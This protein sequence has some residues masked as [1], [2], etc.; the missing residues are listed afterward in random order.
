MAS[1]PNG[2]RILWV[3]LTWVFLPLFAHGQLF[4]PQG[5]QYAP[6]GLLPGDQVYPT[7]SIKAGGGMVVWEDNYTDG[8][9]AGVSAR[10]L[11]GSLSGS[12]SVFRVNATGAFDQSRPCVAALNDGGN[13]FAWQGG[14]PSFQHIYV[15]FMTSA[16]IWVTT[17]DV[18]ASTSTN[19]YQETPAMTVLTGGDVVVIWASINQES[20][21]SM[22]G[23]Y[24]QRFNS[25]GAKVGGEFLINQFTSYNQRNPSIAALS[26]GRFVVVWVSEQQ[27][28]ENT[29]GIYGRLYTAVG[30]PVS[31]EFLVSSA[32]DG[33]TNICANPTVAAA[34][35][36]SFAVSWGQYQLSQQGTT[37]INSNS[38]DVYFRTFSSSAIGGTISRLNTTRF[39][40]Q[41][42]PRLASSGTEYLTVWTSMG[43]DGSREGVYGRYMSGSGVVQGAEFRVNTTTASQQIY[44]AIAGDVSGRFLVSW[45]SFNS[46]TTG[47]DLQA[48]RYVNTNASLSA[49]GA[50]IVTVISSNTLSVSWPMV[51]GFS[52]ANYEVFADGAAS[53]TSVVTNTYWN[54]TGLVPASLHYYRIAYVLTD[55]RRSPLSGSATNT[56]Y[57]AGA[58]WGGIPQEWMAT[59]FGGDIFSWPSPYLDTDGDGASNK[60]EFMAGTD[61]TNTNSVLKIRLQPTTLGLYLNWNTQPGLMYQV[62]TASTPGSAWSNLGGPRFAAGAVDSIFVGGGSSAVYRIQR[63]R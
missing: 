59:Y 38:W 12:L 51:Q 40:D 15:R 49:P 3:C 52:V 26:D 46:I 25:A 31:G 4:T 2:R 53:A 13:V 60:D 48:Q 44:P 32:S 6:A 17:N 28:G 62:H 5:A 35:D 54:A 41:I 39:G 30:A 58:T 20:A 34:S 29:V 37:E 23:V 61:P 42:D 8:D 47:F 56:T 22:Q 24:G 18:M 16:G 14:K 50:P 43:Q 7:I 10:R 9:G 36:G 33:A 55:G 57:S 21:G 19:R 27:A 1:F 45:S 11:D 63:L